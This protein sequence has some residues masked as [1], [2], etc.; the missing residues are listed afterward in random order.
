MNN[1]RKNLLI[2][3]NLLS[4]LHW[5]CSV[6]RGAPKAKCSGELFHKGALYCTGTL[7]ALTESECTEPT[8]C[9]GLHRHLVAD[10]FLEQ[11]GQL[12]LQPKLWLCSCQQESQRH[13]EI[14]VCLLQFS[15]HPKN[16]PGC[17]HFWH[18]VMLNYFCL[19]HFFQHWDAV[20]DQILI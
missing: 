1:S 20:G 9:N 16:S 14:Q 5:H 11:R 12:E 2:S 17:T 7:Q 19:L 13:G 4:I 3:L 8:Q 15:F 18:C 10:I 6:I